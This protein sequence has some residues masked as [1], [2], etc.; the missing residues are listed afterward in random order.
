MIAEKFALFVIDLCIASAS[1]YIKA[2]RILK[3]VIL[4]KTKIL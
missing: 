1:A 4:L 3:C 2:I